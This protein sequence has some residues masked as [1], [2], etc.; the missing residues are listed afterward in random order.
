MNCSRCGCGNAPLKKC[1][2]ECG[3]ILTGK[4][5]NNTTGKWGIRNADG[6]FTP[7]LADKEE[8]MKR[9]RAFR[10][11]NKMYGVTEDGGMI[12]DAMFPRLVAKRITELENSKNPPV[13]WEHTKEILEREGFII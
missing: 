4:T 8:S 1:C 9:V 7:F 10:G 11:D 3:A 5:I 13:D 2:S 6:S 12:Y